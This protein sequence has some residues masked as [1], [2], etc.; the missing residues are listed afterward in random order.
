MTTSNY[1]SFGMRQQLNFQQSRSIYDLG[2]TS[3]N[4]NI[5]LDYS[6]C[7]RNFASAVCS[8]CLTNRG[9]NPIRCPIS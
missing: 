3:L 2:L 1:Q 9:V 7:A 5:D 8:I 4:P 6:L